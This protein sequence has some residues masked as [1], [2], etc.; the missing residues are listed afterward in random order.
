MEN[1]NGQNDFAGDTSNSRSWV[2]IAY[3][4]F[5]ILL[6]A[7]LFVSY[8]WT[9]L[10]SEVGLAVF[11]IFYFITTALVF[12]YVRTTKTNSLWTDA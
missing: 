5:L 6:S 1:R 12:W 4:I 2:G 11:L 8:K 10:T 9:N 7:A 3:S